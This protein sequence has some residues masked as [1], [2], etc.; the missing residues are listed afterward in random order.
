MKYVEDTKSFIIEHLLF[1]C[2][3]FKICLLRDKNRV[4]HNEK[5]E[6]ITTGLG[7]LSIGNMTDVC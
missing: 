7:V 1:M 3:D 2:I 5:K 6:E 4:K